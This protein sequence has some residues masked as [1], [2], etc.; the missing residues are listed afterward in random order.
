MTNVYETYDIVE[1]TNGLG[2]KTYCIECFPWVYSPQ[3]R[4]RYTKCSGKFLYV[5]QELLEFT[6]VNKA[7]QFII[8]LIDEEKRKDKKETNRYRFPVEK[9]EEQL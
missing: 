7:E 1:F 5:G 3:E 9:R 6:D 4:N 8:G 2:E